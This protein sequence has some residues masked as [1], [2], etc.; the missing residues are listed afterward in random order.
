MNCLT[1][2]KRSPEEKEQFMID[3]IELAIMRCELK[4]EKEFK[5]SDK[6]RDFMENCGLEVKDLENNEMML[7]FPW[8]IGPYL[9]FVNKDGIKQRIK[10]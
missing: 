4:S 7:R 9:I 1:L 2:T 10:S 3:I 6:S 8:W 5:E